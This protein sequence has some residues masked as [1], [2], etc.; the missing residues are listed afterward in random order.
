MNTSCIFTGAVYVSDSDASFGGDMLFAKNMAKS[1][2]TT[3]KRVHDF[4][5]LR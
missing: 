2:G 4:M 5:D 3:D 1:G